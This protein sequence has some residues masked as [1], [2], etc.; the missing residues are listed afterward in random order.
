MIARP[1][2]FEPSEPPR[3][4]SGTRAGRS[5]ALRRKSRT[6]RLRYVLPARIV[7][8]VGA[9]TL[10]IVAY[11]GLMAN[12]QRLNYE[13]AREGRLKSRLLAETARYDERLAELRSRE[14]LAR[15]ARE[16]GMHEPLVFARVTIPEPSVVAQ[17]PHGLALLSA[18]APWLR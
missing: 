17:Q 2:P 15:Y 16:L 11:L 18:V 10:V 6:R 8:A 13:L 12:V 4:R 1:L 14:T 7:G 3:R 9:V 5:A